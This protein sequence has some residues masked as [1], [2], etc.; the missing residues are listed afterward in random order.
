M[1][2]CRLSRCPGVG[3]IELMVVLCL[4]SFL[5]LILL[6]QMLVTKKEEMKTSDVLAKAYDLNFISELMKNNI[7]QAGYTPCAAID[8]LHHPKHVGTTLTGIVF[9][10]K[11]Q[12]ALT[13]HHMA[14][15]IRL[16]DSI[17]S[18]SEIAVRGRPAFSPA[19]VLMVADCFHAQVVR[20]RSIKTDG[21]DTWLH[22]GTHLS[23]SYTSPVYIGLWKTQRFF[24]NKNVK[25]VWRLYIQQKR[26]EALSEW[27][28]DMRVSQEIHQG[29]KIIHITFQLPHA[30]SWTMQAR[31]RLA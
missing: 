4:S 10:T 26:P 22:L 12:D 8:Q 2:E 20:L 18:R 14:Q 16:V 15:P 7:R 6:N 30:E 29:E 5:T 1:N 23:F 11:Q 19:D 24:M 25:G 27:V 9:D 21:H 17:I 31:V 13:I 3:L 28:E